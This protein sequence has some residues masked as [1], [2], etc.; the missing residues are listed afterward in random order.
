MIQFF[1]CTDVIVMKPSMCSD[2]HYNE[3]HALFVIHQLSLFNENFA[4]A[5]TSE[6][7]KKVISEAFIQPIY[8][9]IITYYLRARWIIFNSARF[10]SNRAEETE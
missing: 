6:Y 9:F 10:Q 2:E 1:S 8:D 5:S 7:E 4:S 3:V